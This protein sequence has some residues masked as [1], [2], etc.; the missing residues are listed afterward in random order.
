M[1][2]P[3]M[4]AES[5]SNLRA[6][7]YLA[8]PRRFF[9]RSRV[10]PALSLGA[11]KASGSR[12]TRR[13]TREALGLG[14]G[15]AVVTGHGPS[16]QVRPGLSRRRRTCR[17]RAATRRRARQEVR[18][19]TTNLATPIVVPADGSRRRA[20]RSDAQAIL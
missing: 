19:R 2:S 13:P 3:L 15:V 10:L 7:A 4:R 20:G 5:A 14:I 18:T 12:S 9:G 8:R 1:N 6:E 16:V 11:G 17:H